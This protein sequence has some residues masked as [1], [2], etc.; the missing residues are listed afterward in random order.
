MPHPNFARPHV[1]GARLTLKTTAL[2]TCSKE[3]EPKYLKQNDV[4]N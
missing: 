3:L 1:W 4:A 2:D